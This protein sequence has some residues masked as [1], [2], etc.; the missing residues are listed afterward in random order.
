MQFLG[1]DEALFILIAR[2][3]MDTITDCAAN[4][5]TIKETEG[6]VRETGPMPSRI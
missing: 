1:M 5:K 6:T 3:K 2:I 4:M